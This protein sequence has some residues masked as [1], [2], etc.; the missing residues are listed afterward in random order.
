MIGIAV[1]VCAAVT[2]VEGRKLWH[3]DL[4]G[5]NVLLARREGDDLD[6]HPA[7]GRH[8]VKVVDFGSAIFK[9]PIPDK[10]WQVLGR[11]KAL[12]VG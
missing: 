10:G 6:H 9:H 8:V 3:N 12:R 4:H 5:R 1:Q 7:A 2:R 11:S